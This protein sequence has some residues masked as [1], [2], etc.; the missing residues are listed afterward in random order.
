MDLLWSASSE[1]V[2]LF[3]EYSNVVR[4]EY[5]NC[6]MANLSN[7][8]SGIHFT[9]TADYNNSSQFPFCDS[10]PS[11]AFDHP[12]GTIHSPV[13]IP[14]TVHPSDVTVGSHPIEQQQ[15]FN[16]F[17]EYTNQSSQSAKLQDNVQPNSGEKSFEESKKGNAQKGNKKGGIHQSV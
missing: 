1:K 3:V 5:D 6:G 7:N 2:V 4:Y 10:I 13:I 17:V 11:Y 16:I 12:Q 14:S 15:Q 9:S 8:D